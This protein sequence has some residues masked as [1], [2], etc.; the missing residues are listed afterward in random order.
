VFTKRDILDAGS[1]FIQINNSTVASEA[2]VI[3]VLAA[4]LVVA[5]LVVVVAGLVVVIAGLV[6]IVPIVL[7][8]AGLVVVVPIVLVV[9]TS[10]YEGNKAKESKQCVHLGEHFV[11]IIDDD[12]FSSYYLVGKDRGVCTSY[13]IDN[14]NSAVFCDE[15]FAFIC[16]GYTIGTIEY[17]GTFPEVGNTDYFE[18]AVTGTTGIFR[19]HPG[20]Y[21]TAQQNAT[22]TGW[23]YAVYLDVNYKKNYYNKVVT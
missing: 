16:N 19:G 4:V 3:G 18:L 15:E 17:Q 22:A 13:D 14:S 1:L 2:I 20:G 8:V 7:V 6:V 23:T 10:G 11:Q 21:I 9:S 12:L 5:G